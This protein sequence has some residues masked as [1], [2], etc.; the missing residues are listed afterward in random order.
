LRKEGLV[1]L[2]RGK[3]LPSKLPHAQSIYVLMLNGVESEGTVVDLL[4][5]SG[6]RIVL[7]APVPMDKK[8]IRRVSGLSRSTFHHW[9]H[10]LVEEGWLK[11]V[12]PDL[13]V[14]FSFMPGPNEMHVRNLLLHYERFLAS[15]WIIKRGTVAWTNG[16]QAIVLAEST[17]EGELTAFSAFPKYGVQIFLR[18][19]REYALP[20]RELSAQEVFDHACL[21]A[22][23]YR[24][25]V[26]CLIFY[27][28][29]RRKLAKHE[30]FERIIRG[31]IIEGWPT[32]EAEELRRYVKG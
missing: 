9:F 19:V 27:L 20:K 5:K 2:R 28:K 21:L 10:L 4:S 26:L 18:R 12:S 14:S 25:R 16:E 7:S 31:E 11:E 1:E 3:V 30:A 24:R 32:I 22:D 29:N 6:M 8:Q 23:G 13:Y 15:R 17:E